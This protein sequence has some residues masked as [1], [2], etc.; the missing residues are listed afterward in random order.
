[1]KKFI[2]REKELA[3]LQDEYGKNKASLV[4]IYGRRR[5]GKTSLIKEFIRGKAALYFLASEEMEHEN[6]SNFKNMLALHTKNPLLKGGS[7][8]TWDDLFAVF[9]DFP[10]QSKKILVIDEFQY[11]GK[12]NKGFPSVFQRIW[13][14]M[15]QD[16][17]VM[18]ILCGSLISMMESQT[19]TYS[20]PLYGRRTGQIKVDQLSFLDFGK[21]IVNMSEKELVKF[22]AVTGGVPK[23]IEL[24]V[25]ESDIFE[26]IE[27][28]VLE[29]QSF[30]FEEPVFLLEK[31]VSEIGSYFSILKAI[32]QGNHKLGKLAAVLGVSQTGL[33]RYLKTLNNL[34]LIERQVPVTEGNYDKSKKGLYFIR[35]N[36]INFWFKFVY[37]YRS[38]LEMDD[39]TYVL[40]KLRSKFID[41]HVSYV[42]ERVCLEK[43]WRLN[44][45]DRLKFKLL[46]L[47]KWWD[48]N[49]E[50]DM[51][52]INELTGDIL[53]CEC[54][55]TQRK[56]DLDLFYS[57]QEKAK[58]VNWYNNDRR[59]HYGL[60]SISGY[61][62]ELIGL[63]KK[64]DD[65]MLF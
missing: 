9:R 30:L 26:A 27:K 11:L 7:N 65:L 61:T 29:R 49:R 46:K 45:Q 38:Q 17:N 59:E 23:Y 33:T 35:D 16:E 1:M 53:F 10:A 60:F 13:D 3:F 41:N 20:S 14:E 5:I 8:Y 25:G 2:N 54:K 37:P 31:E 21:F 19:L 28:K 58:Q 15:L 39:I 55:Y 18:V 40:E 52:G 50:I 24:F 47:G 62:E 51:V 32:A 64:R 12:V 56:V 63:A 44:K 43:L 34:N 48:G 22:Y 42:Y 4:I 6:I 57:L 36:Y